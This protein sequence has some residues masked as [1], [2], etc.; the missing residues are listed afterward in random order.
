MR[1]SA[2]AAASTSAANSTR[3]KVKQVPAIQTKASPGDTEALLAAISLSPT[4]WNVLEQS[5][6]VE[7][8]LRIPG[9]QVCHQRA[10][11]YC[12]G[13]FNSVFINR[14]KSIDGRATNRPRKAHHLRTLLHH[15]S[16]VLYARLHYSQRPTRR[17]VHSSHLPAVRSATMR[18]PTTFSSTSCV[19]C[20]TQSRSA[21]PLPPWFVC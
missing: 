2:A 20:S 9:D 19:H 6:A 21:T 15:C 16:S 13:Q 17:P 18:R 12:N 1:Q 8:I 7:G 14:L 5:V 4:V 11:F 3:A 10:S